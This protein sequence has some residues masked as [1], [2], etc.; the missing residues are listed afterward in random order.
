VNEDM[1]AEEL[2]LLELRRRPDGSVADGATEVAPL[3]NN[4]TSTLKVIWSMVKKLA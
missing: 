3:Q 2:D 1:P 4:S